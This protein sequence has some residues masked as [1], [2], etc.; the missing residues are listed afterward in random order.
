MP[1]DMSAAKAPPRKRAARS[2]TASAAPVP[3]VDVR[4]N[5]ERRSE[6]LNGLAQLGQGLCLMLGQYADAAA[7]GQH[8]PAVSV[9]LAKVAETSDVVA[10]PID[11][12]IEVGPYGS[13]IA[14]VMPLAMQIAA[15]HGMIDPGK[16]GGQGV[17]PPT[18][19]EA[20][21]K[22]QMARMQSE[23][24]MAQKQAMQEAQRVQAEF[25]QMMADEAKAQT[26]R[27]QEATA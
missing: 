21:M 9:E 11:F 19:L 10:K 15:N 18:V 14:A 5:V 24:L 20:Q 4:S 12:L 17:V 1:I 7:I 26:Q 16:L 22:A 2:N 27:M 6:G 25:D 3:A 13:L 8:F 23:A